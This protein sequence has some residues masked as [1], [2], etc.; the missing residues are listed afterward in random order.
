LTQTVVA[1]GYSLSVTPSTLT[2]THG[3]SGQAKF[4]VTPV[5]DFMSQVT[6]VCAGLPANSSCI[7]SPAN[8]TPDG[9][10]TA[11]TSTLTVATDVSV[12]AAELKAVPR[13]HPETFLTL[14]IIGLPSLVW[15]R[16]RLGKYFGIRSLVLISGLMLGS[17]AGA[18]LSC[19]GHSSMSTNTPKGTNTITVTA[20]GGGTTQTATF[21]LTVQ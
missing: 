6:F 11:V 18:M 3:Q 12:T 19:G 21:T 4:T 17:A 14:L 8:V 2:I 1:P 5:G 13:K 10:N 16:R 7:F 15:S 20:S 9:T